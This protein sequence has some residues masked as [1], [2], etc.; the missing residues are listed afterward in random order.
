MALLG[1]GASVKVSPKLFCFAHIIYTQY[2]TRSR[3][4]LSHAVDLIYIEAQTCN[5]PSVS[6]KYIVVY[7]HRYRTGTLIDYPIIVSE[8][9]NILRCPQ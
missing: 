9:Y 1:P 5:M 8:D 4:N 2:F 3:S 6:T 7:M